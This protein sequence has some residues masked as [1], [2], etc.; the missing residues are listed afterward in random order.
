MNIASLIGLI[1]ISFVTAFGMT[2]GFS[3]MSGLKNCFQITSLVIVLGGTLASAIHSY[4][5]ASFLR[6]T[7]LIPRVYKNSPSMMIN[8]LAITVDIARIARKNVLAIEDTLPKIKNLYL[9][10]SLRLV[11]DRVD[12]EM[13]V[14]IMTSEMKYSDQQKEAD[15]Q[16]VKLMSTLS[17]AWGMI[18]TL[19]GLV[20]LLQNLTGGAEI[21]GKAMATALV[22]TLWGTLLSNGLFLPWYTKLTEIKEEEKVLNEMIRD[23]VLAI[24]QNERPEFVEQDLINFLNPDFKVKYQELKSIRSKKRTSK[25]KQTADRTSETSE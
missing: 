10:S 24:E 2:A 23:G 19:F 20:I 17:P 3:D 14:K 16:M 8:T 22:T 9:R 15:A 4:S 18:G 5:L 1:L 12:R 13:I 25:A 6:L 21:I 7:R 11:V